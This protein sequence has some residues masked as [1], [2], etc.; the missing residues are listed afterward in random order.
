[1]KRIII[2]LLAG[3]LLLGRAAFSRLPRTTGD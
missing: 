1:M 3:V 2:I